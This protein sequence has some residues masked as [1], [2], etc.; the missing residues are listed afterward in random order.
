MTDG[1]DWA[2]YSAA[3]IGGVCL[4][5]LLMKGIE[6]WKKRDKEQKKDKVATDAKAD[7]AS[8]T[9]AASTTAAA[10]TTSAAVPKTANFSKHMKSPKPG[11]IV[12]SRAG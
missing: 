6:Y 12:Q 9:P 10:T 2:I 3:C 1:K 4:G 8:K 11:P 5:L 7:D